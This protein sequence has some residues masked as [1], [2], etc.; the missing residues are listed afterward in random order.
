MEECIASKSIDD[1]RD[2]IAKVVK[3]QNGDPASFTFD[4]AKAK[5]DKVALA[6]NTQ[7]RGRQ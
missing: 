4:L 3:Y 5:T 2:V 6:K 7:I 1:I